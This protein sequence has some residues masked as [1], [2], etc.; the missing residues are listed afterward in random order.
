MRLKSQNLVVLDAFARVE[1]P[2]QPDVIFEIWPA[3]HP[4]YLSAY[5]AER[6]NSKRRMNAAVTGAAVRAAMVKPE[7]LTDLVAEL[8]RKP[9]RREI[10]AHLTAKSLAADDQPERTGPDHRCLLLVK[11][12]AGQ[13]DTDQGRIDWSESVGRE[14][15]ADKTL[16]DETGVQ[17]MLGDEAEGN[18]PLCDLFEAWLLK[19]AADEGLRRPEKLDGLKKKSGPT[20]DG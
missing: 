11:A 13:F 19:V 2:L 1:F 4:A 8:G 17:A 6:K 12:V 20:L 16:V 18:M 14:L 10:V 5:D 7:S 3:D 9:N 15:L